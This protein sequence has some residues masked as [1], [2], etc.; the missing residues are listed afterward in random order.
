[1][2]GQYVTVVGGGLAGLSAAH[3]VLEAGGRVLLLDKMAFLGGNSTK[4]TSGINGALTKTQMKLGIPDSAEV[5]ESDTMKSACGL[6]HSTAPSYTP[7]LAH[8]LTHDSGPAV[9]WLIERFGLDLSLVSQ[10]GGH[11]FPRTHRGKERF[12]GFTITYALMEKLEEIEKQTNGQSARIVTKAEVTELLKGPDGSVTG[13]VYTR[14]GQ[15]HEA[16]GPV[17]IATGGFGADF[18]ATGI[19]AKVRPEL[20]G[21]STTNGEHCT[22]D[23]IKMALAHGA[24]T[25]DLESVQVHPTGLVH[26]DEP[27]AKVK[28]LAA[29]A[30]RGV[31]GVLID[32]EGNRFADE[33]GRRDYV[34]G[35]MYKGKAPFRLC[36]NSKASKEIEWHCKHYVGRGVMKHYSSGADLAREMGIPA[37]KLEATFSKYSADGAQGKCPYGKKFFH[38]LPVDVRD[39]YHVAIVCPVVHYTMGGLAVNPDG[40]VVDEKGQVIQGLYAAGEVAGGIHGRNRLGGNSLLDCVVYGR[41]SGK[42]V[43]RYMFNRLLTGAA[44]V[45]GGA[46]PI[47]VHLDPALKS[48][49]ISWGGGDKVVAAAA[50]TQGGTSAPSTEAPV[51]STPPAAQPVAAQAGSAVISAEEVAKHKTADDCWVIINGKVYDVTSFLPDHPGGKKAIM[52]FAG[53]DA[54]EEFNMLHNPNVLE[55]YMDPSSLKGTLGTSSKL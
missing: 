54:S 19:L 37:A 27:E 30:L 38:N 52:L 47:S 21:F 35:E 13:C 39:S 18:S 7:P 40:A 5:F 29:E 34:S 14:N 17:I 25:Y 42:A 51:S 4:A 12:P 22:G 20:L 31:G 8:V 32:R 36:L 16:H 9:D 43:S 11:S 50:P 28:F 55:K 6:N 48:L 49:Q 1:M 33:L 3:T 10:L 45:P 2:E 23:G 41:Q 46:G 24:G 44:A 15:R 26:P 53:K